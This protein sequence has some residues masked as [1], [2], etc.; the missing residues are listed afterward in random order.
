M[1]SGDQIEFTTSSRNVGDLRR[2]M[3]RCFSMCPTSSSWSSVAVK[4][5]A[6][7]YVGKHSLITRL[8]PIVPCSC[9][10]RQHQCFVTCLPRLY[11]KLS[12]S[13]CFLTGDQEDAQNQEAMRCK[14]TRFPQV[15][16]N[17]LN[18]QCFSTSTGQ[19]SLGSCEGMRSNGSLPPKL[20]CL[21]PK[22]QSRSISHETTTP[23]RCPS[24]TFEASLSWTLQVDWS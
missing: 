22:P 12:G 14:K 24:T 9:H 5:E 11:I 13:R 4:Q 21:R 6:L 20:L 3:Q 1:E 16:K 7:H 8:Q 23:H 15:E 17:I 2:C 18:S 19:R 10:Y